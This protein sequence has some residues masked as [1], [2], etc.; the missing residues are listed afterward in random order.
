MWNAIEAV[1][2]I[3][4]P[5]ID[6]DD[7]AKKLVVYENV[8][9][10]ETGIRQ[11]QTIIP[12]CLGALAGEGAAIFTGGMAG[13]AGGNILWEGVSRLAEPVV[14]QHIENKMQQLSLNCYNTVLEKVNGLISVYAKENNKQLPNSERL[15]GLQLL[16]QEIKTL[17]AQYHHHPVIERGLL[18]GLNNIHYHM[19][20]YNK[21]SL[22]VSP[23][24]PSNNKEMTKIHQDNQQFL[25]LYGVTSHELDQ[26]QHYQLNDYLKKFQQQ[27]LQQQRDIA[28]G[29][30]MLADYQG[31]S[32]FF[33]A[34]GMLGGTAGKI[35]KVGQQIVSIHKNLSLLSG[36]IPG[37]AAPVGFAAL[38]PLSAIFTAGL[39]ILSLFRKKKQGPNP[40][41]ALSKQIA[42]LSQQM[43]ELLIEM[44]EHF[45]Q[46]YRNQQKILETLIEGIRYLENLIDHR[47]DDVIYPTLYSLDNVSTD[48]NQMFQ[49]LS[50][51][52]QAISLREFE[53]VIF[54]T[55]QILAR[56]SG[57]TEEKAHEKL[58]EALWLLELWLTE[59]ACADM[60]NGRLYLA[61]A[62]IAQ[63][64]IRLINQ[65][66]SQALFRD[67]KDQYLHGLIGY[68]AAKARMILG[69]DFA[70]NV[71]FNLLMNPMVWTNGIE[72][73]LNIREDFLQKHKSYDDNHA[74]V[75]EIRSI[76]L[77]A[78]AFIKHIRDTPK[79][80]DLLFEQYLLIAQDLGAVVKE[81]IWKNSFEEIIKEFNKQFNNK[82][83]V[84]DENAL[85][86]LTSPAFAAKV[87]P[88]YQALNAILE[89]R[90]KEINIAYQNSFKWLSVLFEDKQ[91]FVTIID[92]LNNPQRYAENQTPLFR[93][94][95]GDL[96]AP[97]MT[98][99][100][101]SKP[102]ADGYSIPLC[103][104]DLLIQLKIPP[105]LLL[106]ERLGILQFDFTYDYH[107]NPNGFRKGSKQ[108]NDQYKYTVKVN[109]KYAG[110]LISLYE[111]DC[112]GSLLNHAATKHIPQLLDEIYA[113][114]FPN[115]NVHYGDG[116]YKPNAC[117]I[118]TTSIMYAT[119]IISP[120][121]ITTPQLQH[122]NNYNL[123]SQND[124][125]KLTTELRDI[126]VQKIQ[127]IRQLTL[128]RLH[129]RNSDW[130][131]F[132]VVLDKAQATY[133]FLRAY[134]QLIG[135]DKELI[136]QLSIFNGN[137]LN[138]YIKD[139]FEKLALP[140]IEL[141][142][143]PN[144]D[145]V[146]S[147][148]EHALQ[149]GVYKNNTITSHMISR[150]M[151]LRSKIITTLTEAKDQQNYEYFSS[152]IEKHINV[153]L[154][155]LDAFIV[156][157]NVESVVN[158]AAVELVHEDDRAEVASQLATASDS[159]SQNPTIQN[160]GNKR[161]LGDGEVQ[162]T[163]DSAH[164]EPQTNVDNNEA[165]VT[166]PGKQPRVKNTSVTTANSPIES[167]Q[168]KLLRAFVKR[169]EKTICERLKITLNQAERDSLHAELLAELSKQKYKEFINK[170]NVE[171]VQV[172]VLTA[173]IKYL[174]DKNMS[175][176][177][178]Q[179]L[180]NSI[181][182]GLEEFYNKI[183]TYTSQ[184][185]I[186]QYCRIM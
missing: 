80:F 49:V 86:K 123:I 41:Q 94:I 100:L 158:A 69:Q 10:L 177:N 114:W 112:I 142:E 145:V 55:K 165:T 128:K 75:K 89:R 53:N 151:N 110:K 174:T 99:A 44:R 73:Y 13:I 180:S 90:G 33:G 167:E 18:A 30:K 125:Q 109:I 182:Q 74:K 147:I 171:T 81:T 38:S 127:I 181:K 111:F 42:E 7:L 92:M 121:L 160:K 19:K 164:K 155:K 97:L 82:H 24:L 61:Q 131:A 152:N 43:H 77:N 96:T 124:L 40:F 176:N 58:I 102:I 62:E 116:R 185:G 50:G 26:H 156:S 150:L 32:D 161:L 28:A 91:G 146:I 136:N 25:K 37:I 130:T 122:K 47:I 71:N 45:Q 35:G 83:L 14:N 172:E 149:N 105:M 20:N 108:P 141:A 76:A 129:E 104:K 64:E 85:Q 39:T 93:T 179:L 36:S 6:T 144:E 101:P 52:N 23:V 153:F 103:I 98:L 178:K 133:H 117:G 159:Q 168:T 107:H 27:Q 135:I 22:S 31:V 106:A 17:S 157:K 132:Q 79:L 66:F 163:P 162:L 56:D 154:A 67:Y 166:N 140:Q 70:P 148:D 68:L 173:I 72:T 21:S 29:R 169:M 120:F 134:L 54:N 139:Q 1:W 65:T 60:Y 63:N 113:Y 138:K 48:L 16:E 126:V 2:N 143:N 4:N 46:V 15:K 34:V 184:S 118:A 87:G 175:E 115:Y 9:A 8:Y 51:Q 88:I 119:V 137:N 59:R 57:L 170:L 84:V 11:G 3:K 78:L 186:S 183:S 95:I 12:D 5:A